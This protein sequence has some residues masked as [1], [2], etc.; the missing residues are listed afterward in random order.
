MSRLRAALAARPGLWVVLL[1]HAVVFWTVVGSASPWTTAPLECAPGAMAEML[2]SE[3]GWSVWDSFHGALAGMFVGAL[4]GLPL[5]ALVGVTPLAIKV[6]TWL[7]AVAL[8]VVAWALLERHVD[9]S[10]ALLGAAG[11]AFAPPVLF[12]TSTVLGN[13]H[14]TQLIFDYG[15]ALFALALVRADR[16]RRAW[17]AFGLATGLA[18][19]NCVG[20]FPFVVIAWAIVALGRFGRAH[21]GRFGLAAATATL[22]LLPYL[23]KLL[24]RHPFGLEQVPADQTLGRL[25]RL[26][27][28]PTKLLDLL[29]PELP[30][31]LHVHDALPGWPLGLTTGLEVLWVAVVWVGLGGA[32]LL[33]VRRW[34]AERGRAVPVELIPG[35]FA[36][37]FI[38][39]YVLLQ[40]R[41]E[42][43]PLPFTN[44]R[45]MGHRILPPLLAALLVGSAIGWRS[46]AGRAAGRWPG[47]LLAIGLAPAAIGLLSQAALVQRGAPEG[48]GLSSY[49]ASCGDLLG[50]AVADAFRSDP[51][52][53]LAAC[54][55]LPVS[56]AGDCR[57]GAARATGFL[58]GAL[59]SLPSEVA[60]PGW[61]SSRLALF[62]S[63]RTAC[64]GLE[65]PG[66]A[67]CVFGLGWFV[68]MSNWGRATWPLDACDSLPQRDRDACWRGVGFPVGDH[69]HPYPD[70]PRSVLEQA[71][72]ARRALVAEGA[73]AAIGRT[74][75]SRALGEHYCASFDDLAE[76]CRRGVARSWEGRVAR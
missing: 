39:A 72:K 29:Y 19:F 59:G 8:V 24:W 62:G 65:E 21:L 47:L 26:D 13:W 37:A 74:W 38:A 5:F 14:W 16:G 76:A 2:L 41:L 11:L 61:T 66:R 22:G 58:S 57:L 56:L 30:W 49:R 75:D 51:A 20:S 54:D 67:E 50:F 27:P 9:R 46:F 1:L 10:A 15:L 60:P 12:H 73:G 32:T 36:L 64:E 6:V 71:P 31:A 63:A 43:L 17:A 53:G 42:M 28:D 44:I 52:G 33:G 3:G 23:Y 68:G 48:V 70:K 55:E 7:G 25:S 4:A 69:L 18:L 34:R 35:L 40:I 45:E